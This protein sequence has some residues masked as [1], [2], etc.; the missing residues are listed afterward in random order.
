MR[1]LA[2]HRQ[3]PFANYAAIW[4]WSVDNLD[5]FWASLW[6]YY[7][8]QAA[9][10][11]TAILPDPSMPGARWFPGAQLNYAAHVFRWMNEATPALLF[12]SERMPLVEISWQR[13]HDEVAALAAALKDLGIVAGDRVVAYLPNIPQTLVAFL[14][15][16]SIGAIWSSCSPDF[17]LRSVTDRFAQIEPRVLFATDGYSYNGRLHDRRETVDAIRAALPTLIC[18]VL[19]PYAY[20]EQ[21]AAVQGDVVRLAD[22]LA[23]H[24]GAALAF[25]PVPFD[26]PLWILYSSGTTGLP[27]AIVQGHGGILLEHLRI[28]GLH[29]NVKPGDRIF[30]YTTTGWMMWNMIIGGL[31]LGAT[32]AL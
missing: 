31:L 13:L 14:A 7:Q 4:Q 28:L 9:S 10:P 24:R 18:T 23:R 6:D 17:G 3:L 29:S 2:E 5:A 20:P 16:A 27:K 26:H 22:L 21:D 12:Q 8:I 19:V 15:C 25:T 11:Y 30:W 32:V 1:W